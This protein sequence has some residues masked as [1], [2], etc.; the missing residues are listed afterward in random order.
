MKERKP[1]WRAEPV[2]CFFC[3]LEEHEILISCA[4]A[5]VTTVLINL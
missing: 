1:R 3:M 5:A 4:V 2:K